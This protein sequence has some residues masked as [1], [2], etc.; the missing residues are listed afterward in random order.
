VLFQAF[1]PTLGSGHKTLQTEAI[2]SPATYRPIDGSG[3]GIWSS[4]VQAR[5]TVRYVSGLAPPDLKPHPPCS[6][7]KKKKTNK[8]PKKK[9]K[10]DGRPS[11]RSAPTRSYMYQAFHPTL[12]P[13]KRRSL[14]VVD[15]ERAEFTMQLFRCDSRK[16][17]DDC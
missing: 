7:Q 1:T 15:R 6:G 5:L 17:R 10:K 11:G 4:G 8:N 16:W 9:R 14:T 12:L 2:N 3:I 13:V